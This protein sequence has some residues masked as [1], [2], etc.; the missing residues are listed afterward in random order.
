VTLSDLWPGFQGHDILRRLISQSYFRT[1]IGNHTQ[2]IEWY[3]VWW[4]RLSSKHVAR[5]CQHQLTSADHQLHDIS[6][7]IRLKFMVL[8]SS[9]CTWFPP[10]CKYKTVKFYHSRLWLPPSCRLFIVGW[11]KLQCILG[12]VFII[13]RLYMDEGCPTHVLAYI[14]ITLQNVT[15]CSCTIKCIKEQFLFVCLAVSHA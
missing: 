8:L 7:C 2:S 9:S 13:Y 6:F 1:L 3:H 15:Y 10:K 5:F 4:P 11:K 12:N 14:S